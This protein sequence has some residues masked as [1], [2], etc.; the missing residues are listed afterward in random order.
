M[1]KLNKF[2]S[3]NKL[4]YFCT[5]EIENS[6]T[7][8]SKIELILQTGID[9]FQLRSK[10]HCYDE[11]LIIGQKCQKLCQKYQTIFIVNDSV[12]LALALNADGVHLGQTDGNVETARAQLGINKIIGV[13]CSTLVQYQQINF[14]LVNYVGV[15]AIYFSPTKPDAIIV[16][17]QVLKMMLQHC[18]VSCV[19]IGGIKINN[20]KTLQKQGA[21]AFAFI[22]QIWNSDDIKLTIE[23]LQKTI[24]LDN[25]NN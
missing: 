14:R 16:A 2:N 12:K 20:I 21:N 11:L 15:G 1:P 4:L 13:S 18:S 17:P 25:T 10:K 5:D 7:F 23:Q 19:L 22:S 8:Y 24:K 3:K 9:V 6:I